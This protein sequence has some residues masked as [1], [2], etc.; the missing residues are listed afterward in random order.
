M[1]EYLIP[2]VVMSAVLGIISF[3]SYPTASEKTVKF[4][5]TVLLLYTALTPIFSFVSKLTSED[6]K[7]YIG[8]FEQNGSQTEGEYAKVAEEAFKE[9]ISQ[10]LFT[11]YGI[12]KE[13]ADIYI[14]GFDFGNMRAEKI[15]IVLSNA[16]A[17]S[18]FRGIEEYITESG[19][20]ECEVNIKIG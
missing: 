3:V 4:A 13:N 5:A 16:G 11:K 18:D 15:K 2:V 6:I 12:E 17:F 9:G 1:G 8:D 7:D 14:F 19:L 20:G 10:L